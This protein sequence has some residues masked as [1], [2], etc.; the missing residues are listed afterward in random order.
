MALWSRSRN[1]F[2]DAPCLL[3]AHGLVLVWSPT[4]AKPFYYVTSTLPRKWIKLGKDLHQARLQWAALEGEASS[5]DDKTFAIITKRYEQEIIPGKAIRTQQDNLTE[6]AKLLEV[7]GAVP[8][9]AIRP[10]DVRTY[11]DLRGQ[12]AKV[13]ANRPLGQDSYRLDRI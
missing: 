5:P 2:S 10:Q 7:F 12:T 6:L 4:R 9:D 1:A 8:I 13:R 11:L 3:R